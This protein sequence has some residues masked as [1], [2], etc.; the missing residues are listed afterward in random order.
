[1]ASF[2]SHLEC[3]YTGKKYQAGTVL[4]VSDSGKPLLVKY[5]LRRISEQFSRDD[6]SNSNEDGFWR[7]S[8]LLPVEHQK[9]RVSLGEVVTPLISLERSAKMI[10]A[11]PGMALI[12]DESRLPT[13]SVSYTHLTLPTTPYV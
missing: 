13:G 8:P 11:K 9:N 3:A 2:V 7:Y 6:I 1:M 10:G 4:S 5:D 12:K